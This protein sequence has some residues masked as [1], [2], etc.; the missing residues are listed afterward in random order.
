MIN[1]LQSGVF[2]IFEGFDEIIDGIREHFDCLDKGRE[3][4]YVASRQVV[5]V[6]STCIKTCHRGNFE[7]ALKL[8]HET[9]AINAQMINAL[10]NCP[11]L[12]YGGFV[13]DAMKE[14]VEAAITYAALSDQPIPAPATL[15]VD[16]ATWLNGLAE[17]AGEFRRHVLD[18]IR[19]GNVERAERFL[20]IMD[21]IY[22]ITMSFDYPNAISL[23]LRGR[24]DA[25]RGFVERTRGDMTTALR[26]ERLEKKIAALEE[27]LSS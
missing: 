11:E 19:V 5:R 8:L 2:D 25:V 3:E 23:G 13:S 21:D 18:Q 16:D 14:Y 20:G 27:K 1:P 17:A 26:Q 12:R 6:A 24:S 9:A 10:E 22:S 7:E 15:G 4:A